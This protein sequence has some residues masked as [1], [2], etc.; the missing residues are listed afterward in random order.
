VPALRVTSN[1]FLD[2]CSRV[3]I[4]GKKSALVQTTVGQ[5]RQAPLTPPMSSFSLSIE[6]LKRRGASDPGRTAIR[7]QIDGVVEKRTREQKPYI[8]ILLRDLTASFV[9]RVWSDH[10]FYLQSRELRAG[11]FVEIEGEFSINSA[12]GLEARNW[13]MRLL[14]AAEQTDLL[15]GPSDIQEKQELDYSDIHAFAD[16][17]RDPRL[18][19]LSTMFLHEF[20]DRMRRAAGAR[21]YHHARRGGLVEHV[22]QMMRAAE[23]LAA[24]YPRLNR[25]LL[26][27]GILFH[28]CG[29]LW[30]N[31]FLKESFVMPYDV[32][33]ELVGHISIGIEL[34]NRLWHKLKES[35]DFPSWNAL[36]PDSDSVRL[37]L[38]HLV[39]AHHGE[40]QFG[41]PLEPKTPEAIAL[42]MIDNLDA[43]LEMMFSAY[44]SGHRLHA[45]IIERVRPLASNLVEP[46][47]A[48][49]REEE[50]SG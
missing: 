44:Q 45:E 48:F 43:K 30:E 36:S 19:A 32:R 28:D 42:H 41:S 3:R 25:D 23:A 11:F 10:P 46:L 1:F 26:L 18:R 17:I 50:K 16:S 14:T 13:T 33:G 2:V 47:P 29:K 20:G 9:L 31:C 22:A 5:A 34:V 15:A 4:T 27:A 24:S 39:A 6:E 37:H 12:F 21:N 40:R 7:A 38:I 8:E 35:A 49:L